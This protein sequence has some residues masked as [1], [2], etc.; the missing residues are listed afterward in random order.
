MQVS[1][2]LRLPVVSNHNRER[3]KRRVDGTLRLL[4]TFPVH[5]NR[6]IIYLWHLMALL[7]VSSLLD[8]CCTSSVAPPKAHI[9]SQLAATDARK[10][11]SLAL[12]PH[13]FSF[14]FPRSSSTPLRA[15]SIQKHLVSRRRRRRDQRLLASFV[16]SVRVL[17]SGPFIR[18]CSQTLP[19]M[20]VAETSVSF[21]S[22]LL[23]ALFVC[24]SKK[25]P[26]DSETFG[27]AFSSCVPLPHCCRFFA[28]NQD[29]VG[30]LKLFTTRATGGAV[31]V[32]GCV[33]FF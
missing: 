28:A 25:K 19:R 18:S 22:T 30:R 17:S 8:S 31:N 13:C 16:S 23:F 4:V 2:S 11:I 33:L 14:T 5:L 20:Y 24:Q 9:P 10:P 12:A 32:C 7:R 6:S 27:P 26:F 29:E 3:E 15:Q 1:R 21:L